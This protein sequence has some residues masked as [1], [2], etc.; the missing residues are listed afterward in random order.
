MF[1]L[2]MP[3]S[4]SAATSVWKGGAVKHPHA[5]GPGSAGWYIGAV[6][7]VRRS[8]SVRARAAHG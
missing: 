5:G 2:S 6:G 7:A 8:S 3:S 1:V 4:A